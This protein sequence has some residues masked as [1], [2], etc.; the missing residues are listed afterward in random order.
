MRLAKPTQP[1]VAPEGRIAKAVLAEY[2]AGRTRPLTEI[3]AEIGVDLTAS[4]D[5][6]RG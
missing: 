5:D 1:L 4:F 6:K 3:A 2:D